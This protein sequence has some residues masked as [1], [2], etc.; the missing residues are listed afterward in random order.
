M[1]FFIYVITLNKKIRNSTWRNKQK[2]TRFKSLF[3]NYY[4]FCIFFCYFFCSVLTYNESFEANGHFG[5]KLKVASKKRISH[6]KYKRALM[7]YKE[8]KHEE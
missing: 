8:L 1:V 4:E 7:L 3:Q 2:Q 6:K 5:A